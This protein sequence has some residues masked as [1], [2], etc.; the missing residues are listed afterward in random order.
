MRRLSDIMLRQGKV[1]TAL[2]LARQAVRANLGDPHSHNHEASV[3]LAAEDYEQA[4][5]SVD[6]ALKLAPTDVTFLRR[7]DYLRA[8]IGATAQK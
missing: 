4:A 5:A 1:D 7:A 2:S 3:L 8:L 6:K